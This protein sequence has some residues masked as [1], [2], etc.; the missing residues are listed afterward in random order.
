MNL[1]ELREEV[2]YVVSAKIGDPDQDYDGGTTYP[3]KRI[4][5][6]INQSIRTEYR[7]VINDCGPDPF[8]NTQPATWLSGSRL[9]SLPGDMRRGD[10]LALFDV[11]S[12]V[13]GTPIMV[14]ERLTG[15]TVYWHDRKTLAW[16]T[17]GPG[18]ERTLALEHTARPDPL[19]LAAQE[20][21]LFHQEHH[22]VFVWGA[23]VFLKSV[24]DESVPKIWRD[25]HAACRE[26]LIKFMSTYSPRALAYNGIDNYY[27]GAE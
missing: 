25:S 10:L 15:A 4:D 20:P 21:L 2:A 19:E 8:W 1:A 26:Q 12:S 18:S 24:T 16:G 22:D 27:E 11:S 5:R 7:E 13:R 23:A 9:F 3:W 17:T 14:G 6:A